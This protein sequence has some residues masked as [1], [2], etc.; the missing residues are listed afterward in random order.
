MII[1]S[2]T[3]KSAISKALSINYPGIKIYKNKVNQGMQR[4]CFFIA[5]IETECTKEAKDRRKINYLVNIRYHKDNATRTELDEIGFNLLDILESLED[6]E[7]I[8][9]AKNSRYEIV[10]DV[11]QFFTTYSISMI[12]EKAP[13]IKMN[14]LNVNGGLK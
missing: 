5:Q 7:T 8:A 4:P 1:T 9:Y 6:K 2:E 10:D 3:V 11:L 13:G 14:D 12:R